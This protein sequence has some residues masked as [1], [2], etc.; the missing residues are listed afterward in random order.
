MGVH[1]RHPGRELPALRREQPSAV[2]APT[3]HGQHSAPRGAFPEEQ[4]RYLG[5]CGKLVAAQVQKPDSRFAEKL[6]KHPAV[7]GHIGHFS[8]NGDGLVIHPGQFPGEAQSLHIL[9]GR[10]KVG[11]G[12]KG[13]AVPHDLS[14]SDQAIQLRLQVAVAVAANV[15][16]RPGGHR[17]DIAELAHIRGCVAGPNDLPE[18][19]AAVTADHIG[20]Q[21][22]KADV[23]MGF[24]NQNDLLYHGEH[25]SGKLLI[26]LVHQF[27]QLLRHSNHVIR[28]FFLTGRHHVISG[29]PGKQYRA[30]PEALRAHNIPLQIIAYHDNP[31]LIIIR[32][33]QALQGFLKHGPGG[34]FHAILLRNR[35]C[36]ENMIKTVLCHGRME[37][38]CQAIGHHSD[39][40]S[41]RIQ[42]EHGLLCTGNTIRAEHNPVGN[43]ADFAPL[44]NNCITDVCKYYQFTINCL[45]S[46]H[47]Q[48]LHRIIRQGSAA[49]DF[50]P[51]Q[52]FKNVGI[53]YVFPVFETA[54]MVQKIR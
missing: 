16:Q 20:C 9:V 34:F 17:P 18:H 40:V 21:I 33:A 38:F 5:R 6:G 41:L 54:E 22:C 48:G 30:D 19:V 1:Q 46:F 36:R 32:Q 23:E 28:Y 53:L 45:N 11:V 12:C 44:V 37:G 24:E 25:L 8:G 42:F 51:V 7:A 14:V 26:Q 31:V 47:Y 50:V 29:R 3:V 15:P 4:L 39:G 52:S 43:L 13:K 27:Q 2:A 35:L 49:R 10:G